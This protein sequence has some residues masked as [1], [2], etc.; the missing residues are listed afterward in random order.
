LNNDDSE[1][2]EMLM[3][4]EM[5]VKIVKKIANKVCHQMVLIHDS[6]QSYNPVEF[7]QEDQEGIQV[8]EIKL[9]KIQDAD[10]GPV[11]EDNNKIITQISE[12][13]KQM[14][15]KTNMSEPE[16]MR[17]ELKKIFSSRKFSL[18]I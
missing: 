17:E 8:E 1:I 14:I 10:A 16:K 13:D 9:E 3:S 6:L 4:P 7:S 12:A 11:I 18:K 15:T 2:Q 5:L